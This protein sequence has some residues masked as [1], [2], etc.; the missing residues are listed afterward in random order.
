MDIHAA[1]RVANLVP[2]AH[3]DT[4]QQSAHGHD[5]AFAILRDAG[6]AEFWPVATEI[7]RGCPHRVARKTFLILGNYR[8][9]DAGRAMKNMKHGE[10]KLDFWVYRAL[11]IE[12]LRIAEG[13]ALTVA[14]VALMSSIYALCFGTVPDSLYAAWWLCFGLKT[15]CLYCPQR[16]P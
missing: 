16:G 5:S 6:I 8:N 13:K 10:A 9:D 4:V 14:D 15:G 3:A 7:R 2:G 11:T 12:M 1:H